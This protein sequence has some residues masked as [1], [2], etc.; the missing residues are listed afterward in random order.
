MVKMDHKDVTVKDPPQQVEA[1]QY[2]EWKKKFVS[3]IQIEDSRMYTC[4]IDGYIAPTHETD[5]RMIVISYEKMNESKNGCM[6]L[7]IKL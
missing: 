7:K 4:I 2:A 5:G 1:S 6:M 3:F